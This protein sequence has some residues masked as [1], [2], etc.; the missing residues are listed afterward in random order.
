MHTKFLKELY[1]I[2]RAYGSF[3]LLT[4][5]A[6]TCKKGRAEETDHDH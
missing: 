3:W 5:F 1:L 6:S 4:I 2:M